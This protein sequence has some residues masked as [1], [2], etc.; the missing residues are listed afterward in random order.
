M[1]LLRNDV[2]ARRLPPATRRVRLLIV[3]NG[4]LSQE[5]YLS[6]GDCDE[7]IV[8][9]QL[10][11]ESSMDLL[12]RAT[13]RIADIERT[14]NQIERAIVA[15]APLL[16]PQLTAVRRVLLLTIL[17]HAQ[18][19]GNDIELVLAVDEDAAPELRRN[20][21]ALVETL[22]AH[23]GSRQRGPSEPC[24]PPAARPA[25]VISLTLTNS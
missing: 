11:G 5:E 22:V 14:G 16:D 12:V 4:A 23:P 21:M 9:R 10:E 2:R 24:T 8:L 15:M 3:E 18:A 20:L 6:L 19:V 7:L 1:M 17:R 25:R 13:V